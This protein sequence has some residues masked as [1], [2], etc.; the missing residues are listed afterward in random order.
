MP[1]WLIVWFWLSC[2]H[3]RSDRNFFLEN[4][5]ITTMAPENQKNSSNQERK[6]GSIELILGPMFSG[7]STELM[8]RL[9]RYQVKSVFSRWFRICLQHSFKKSLSF[10][11]SSFLDFVSKILKNYKANET[12]NN[13]PKR[14]FP[15]S[16]HIITYHLLCIICRLPSTK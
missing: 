9:K 14:Y 2:P 4:V 6:K 3:T 7:K 1:D 12:V 16:S 10:L 15:H 11:F 13:A 5:E 8:R